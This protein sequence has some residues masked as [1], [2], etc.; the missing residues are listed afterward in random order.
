[1]PGFPSFPEE[2]NSDVDE[3]EEEADVGETN[4]APTHP[5]TEGQEAKKPAEDDIASDNEG[6]ETIN[7]TPAPPVDGMQMSHLHQLT[8]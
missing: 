1:M 8:K 3:E 5:A 2:L 6:K 7:P 4:P